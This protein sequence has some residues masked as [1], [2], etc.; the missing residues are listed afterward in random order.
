M[1]KTELIGGKVDRY[2]LNLSKKYAP[3]WAG[4]EVAREIVCN[5]MDAAPDSMQIVPDGA[6]RLT[7][8]TPTVP[9]IAELFVIGEGSKAP[10]GETI[11]QF[12][13]GLK[14]AA[15]VATRSGGS[16]TLHIPGRTVTF[17]F[18]EVLGA[19][20]LH[21][22]IAP[23]PLHTEGYEAVIEMQGVGHVTD[24]RI[25]TD[26]HDGPRPKMESGSLRVYCKGVYVSTLNVRSIYDWNLK[27]LEINRDRSM[28]QQFDAAW[29]IGK[30]L[31]ANMTAEIA[32]EIIAHP[33]T[34]EADQAIEYHSGGKVKK[35]AEAFRAKYGEK[36]CIASKDPRATLKA[37]AIGHVVIDVPDELAKVLH[38]HGVHY[39]HTVLPA[40][41]ELEPVDVTPYTA[42][43]A[44]CR[45]LDKVIGA[46]P[47]KVCV[48]ANYDDS[49]LGRCDTDERTVWLSEQ[50][51]TPE[52]GQRLIGTYLHEAAHIISS[53]YDGT[54][55]F[56]WSMTQI[57]GRLGAA[58]TQ[59]FDGKV[60]A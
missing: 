53:A 7:V 39:A 57:M 21:A 43:I 59:D 27:E 46:P 20:V 11:G 13:E 10:G 2:S 4:W 45:S 34:I 31:E 28:V 37:E 41:Y 48:F 9:E 33:D 29:A 19:E 18:E 12:G 58:L 38:K 60:S 26:Q 36:A 25:L 14:L 6:N 1:G 30:W 35:V 50:L 15:M 32:A 17:G 56:E 44:R 40:H 23:N 3:N 24:G 47:F 52:N 22:Y 8:T 51:F 55:E 54:Q 16:L 42:Q 5:A 49:A